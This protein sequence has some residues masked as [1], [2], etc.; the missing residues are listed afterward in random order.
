MKYDSPA[1]PPKQFVIQRIFEYFSNTELF[2]HLWSHMRDIYING[3]SELCL[4]FYL[5]TKLKMESLALFLID[6]LRPT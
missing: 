4:S 2:A 6:L 3:I 1:I 5:H